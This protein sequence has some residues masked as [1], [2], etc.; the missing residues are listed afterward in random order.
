VHAPP[1]DEERLAF[2]SSIYPL[3]KISYLFCDAH[4]QVFGFF[5]LKNGAVLKPS[6][7]ELESFKRCPPYMRMMQESIDMYNNKILSKYGKKMNATILD[8]PCVINRILV[9]GT[10]APSFTRDFMA[11]YKRSN[12]KG[13][14]SPM[15]GV[16]ETTKSIP[17][18][19]RE[20]RSSSTP[21]NL[22]LKPVPYKYPND[23]SM[24]SVEFGSRFQPVYEEAHLVAMSKAYPR[25]QLVY[26]YASKSRGI[27]GRWIMNNG[28]AHKV[29]PK[30]M[31]EIVMCLP[32]FKKLIAQSE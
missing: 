24:K 2:I 7:G 5:S 22:I 23:S 8:A 27:Y 16:F 1:Y 31:E 17:A 29:P 20:F 25:A 18:Q 9:T 32:G 15:D 13:H 6:P 14:G 26:D 21:F 30:E 10:G 19:A 4:T 3:L 11:S 28:N 12:M